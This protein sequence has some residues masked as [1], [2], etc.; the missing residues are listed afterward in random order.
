[1]DNPF[2]GRAG[3]PTGPGID[4]V[5]VT[6][7]DITDFDDVAVALYVETGGAVNFVSVKGGTRSVQLPNYG[8]LLCGVS[9]VN[10][11]GTTASGIHAIVVT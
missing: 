4:Y 5:P 6:P 8:Y 2:A 1:M 3:S 9:R 10:A 7:N 11:T